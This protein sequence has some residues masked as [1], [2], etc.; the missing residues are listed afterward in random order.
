MIEAE[1]EPRVASIEAAADQLL[2]EQFGPELFTDV[3]PG[4]DRVADPGFVLVA[5]DRALA[6]LTCWRSAGPRTCNS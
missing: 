6:S 2:V 1:D 3:T 5:A 4:K